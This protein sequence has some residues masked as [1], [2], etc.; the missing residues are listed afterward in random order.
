M[1]VRVFSSF[2]AHAHA[3][4]HA[5]MRTHT[6]T[7]TQAHKHT[8]TQAH[9]HTT[10]AHT[11]V[12]AHLHTR[13]HAHAHIHTHTTHA[14]PS[15]ELTLRVIVL[16]ATRVQKSQTEVVRV[17]LKYGADPNARQIDGPYSGMSPLQLAR[18]DKEGRK[19]IIALLI[20]AGAHE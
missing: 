7:S 14:H 15:S 11:H 17:L 10:H 13:T 2:L 3:C 20:A 19:E 9:K 6:H 1:G 16:L 5:Q 12:N 4:A 18:E 8:S